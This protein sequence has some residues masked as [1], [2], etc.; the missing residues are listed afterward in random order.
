M[1]DKLPINNNNRD[2][3]KFIILNNYISLNLSLLAVKV[4]ILILVIEVY[5]KLSL[6]AFITLKRIAPR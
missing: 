1:Q 4:N 3:F 6:K 5:F 2:L